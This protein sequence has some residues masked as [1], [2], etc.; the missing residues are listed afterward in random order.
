MGL[1]HQSQVPRLLPLHQFARVNSNTTLES[2]CLASDMRERYAGKLL[3]PPWSMA[4]RGV[5]SRDSGGLLVY[6]L[7]NNPTLSSLLN[8][9]LLSC[10]H[11]KGDSQRLH[12]PKHVS[13]ACTMHTRTLFGRRE[14]AKR[15][16][17]SGESAAEERDFPAK[18]STR[19][20]TLLL[21]IVPIR[22]RHRLGPHE[23]LQHP[24][25]GCS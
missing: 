12:I 9:M 15:W 22:S 23:M 13:N 17:E 6:I 5:R 14:N 7:N 24:V 20:T 2:H 10:R 19:Q 8:V 1:C 16:L 3:P 18:P 25:G 11:D 21:Q 4:A